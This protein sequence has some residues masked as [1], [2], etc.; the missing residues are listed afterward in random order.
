MVE[1]LEE[2]RSELTFAT[3]PIL[4]TLE[5]CIPGY[6]RHASLVE[7]DEVEVCQRICHTSR[8][9]KL[10]LV[11]ITDPERHS[12]TLQRTVVLTLIS[13]ADP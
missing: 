2:T 4:S 1:P 12:A 10:T 3:E 13:T 9:H 5:L 8:S 7:L 6:G 11:A